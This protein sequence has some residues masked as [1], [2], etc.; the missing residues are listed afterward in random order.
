MLQLPMGSSIMC[1]WI[2]FCNS[3]SNKQIQ[4]LY[5]LYSYSFS[6]TIVYTSP[7]FFQLLCFILIT[8]HFEI[9]WVYFRP[10]KYQFPVFLQF[11][12]M[13]AYISPLPFHSLWSDKL[14]YASLESAYFYTPLIVPSA[15]HL[16][17]IEDGEFLLYFVKF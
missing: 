6:P 11:V 7:L 16:P 15:I 9:L 12:P 4:S 3:V 10:L 13:S 5:L 1:E 8:S 14:V 17:P 2:F